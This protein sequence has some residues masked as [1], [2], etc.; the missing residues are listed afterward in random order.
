[1]IPRYVPSPNIGPPFY[2]TFLFHFLGDEDIL[3][4]MIPSDVR[5]PSIYVHTIMKEIQHCLRAVVVTDSNARDQPRFAINEAVNH[6]LVSDE[7]YGKFSHQFYTSFSYVT[8]RVD[9]HDATRNS[10]PQHCRPYG[11]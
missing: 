3:S 7:T 1:M 11:E 4:P 6:Q 10:P 8:H 2:P 9:R 5:W